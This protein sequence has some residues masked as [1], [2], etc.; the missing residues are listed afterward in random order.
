M[1]PGD[2]IELSV[3]EVEQMRAMSVAHSEQRMALTRA[4]AAEWEKWWD[5]IY[6]AKKID[7]RCET[8]LG[9]TALFCT[10]VEAQAA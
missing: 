2:K 10:R 5:A 1:S 3:E 4:H 8:I 6:S 7:P 9:D